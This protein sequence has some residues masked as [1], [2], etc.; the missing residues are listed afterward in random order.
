MT[1]ENY[2]TIVGTVIAAL[3]LGVVITVPLIRL[4]IRLS[5]EQ[6]IYETILKNHE[7]RISTIEKRNA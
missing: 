7:E 5:R 6:S 3:S 1:I 2:G 4:L